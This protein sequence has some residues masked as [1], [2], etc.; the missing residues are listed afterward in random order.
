LNARPAY[1]IPALLRFT[2]MKGKQVVTFDGHRI[3]PVVDERDDCVVVE[4]GVIS[5]TRHVVPRSFL[6]EHDGELQST[7][8]KEV[9][10]EAPTVDSDDWSAE[11]VR[12]H[13]GLDGPYEIESDAEVGDADADRPA[14]IGADPEPLERRR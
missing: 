7:V 2:V 11:D 3:G 10:D 1:L 9:F 5:K 6:H 12:L 13:F 4:S 8:S 14:R